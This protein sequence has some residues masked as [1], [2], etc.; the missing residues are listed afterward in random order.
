MLVAAL[1]L[2]LLGALAAG[3]FALVQRSDAQDKARVAQAGR[4]AAQSRGAAGQ[5]PDLALLLALEAG[6]LDDS[7]DT[8]GALLGALEHGSRIRSWL[9]GFDAPVIATAFSPDGTTPGDRDAGGGHSLGHDDMAPARTSPSNRRR[10]DGRRGST[11]VPTDGRWP[12]RAVQGRVELWDVSTAK[13]V[14][15]LADP[16]AVTSDEPA[17]AAVLFS[18]D[19]SVIAAG[20]K[21]MNHVTLWDDCKRPT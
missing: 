15:E 5:H 18:P 11:S 17:L 16:V 14:G 7:I 9:Q 3:G 8:R 2:L 12:S 13:Q 20:S 10:V 21:A 4:L 19:G 6:R 1:A